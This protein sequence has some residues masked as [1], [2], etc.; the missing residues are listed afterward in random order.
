MG[1]VLPSTGTSVVKCGIGELEIGG[2]SIL[3]CGTELEGSWNY[4]CCE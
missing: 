2:D 1:V 4:C 3:L